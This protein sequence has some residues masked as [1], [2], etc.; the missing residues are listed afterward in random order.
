[1]LVCFISIRDFLDYYYKIE[2]QFD[3]K[4]IFK[5]RHF[6]KYVK[7]TV[8]INSITPSIHGKGFTIVWRDFDKGIWVDA[9]FPGE[10]EK[11]ISLRE[12]GKITLIGKLSTVVF[13]D[14]ETITV[15]FL[16]ECRFPKNYS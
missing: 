12:G 13:G 6:D 10:E 3:K 15:I 9:N 8:I 16:E 11:A 5:K 7:W 2:N 14:K 1:M 4:E